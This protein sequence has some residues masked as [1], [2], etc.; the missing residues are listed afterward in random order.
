MKI[1]SGCLVGIDC[2]FDGKNRISTDLIEDF[3]KGELIPLC[4]EQL[5]GLPTPRPPSRIVNGNGY[6]VLDGR[7]RVVNQKGD[8]VTEKFIKGATEVLKITKIL[9]DEEAILESKSPS[10]GC[11][12]IYDGISGELVESDGILTVLLK[13]NGMRA[14][15]R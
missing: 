3:K 1:V 10:C 14:I 9:D 6:K 11:G 4:P 5:G 2:R 12:R 13:R 7:T 15:P 8:D